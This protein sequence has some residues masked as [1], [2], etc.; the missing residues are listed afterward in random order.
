VTR[1]AHTATLLPNGKVLMI[2]NGQ[3]GEA[4]ID[5]PGTGAWVSA[6][7][8]A[9]RRGKYTATLLPG[10]QVIIVGGVTDIPIQQTT[11]S[12]HVNFAT[13][14]IELYWPPEDPH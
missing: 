8:L 13:Y 9:L 14:G 2:D 5:S 12:D 3:H 10:G 7:R 4:Q 11:T 1:Y 6:G